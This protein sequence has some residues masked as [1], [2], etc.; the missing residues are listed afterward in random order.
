MFPEMLTSEGPVMASQSVAVVST[1][2]VAMVSTST[3]GVAGQSG[4]GPEERDDV[5]MEGEGDRW[6]H[7]T[8][9][10]SHTP[11]A[12]RHRSFHLL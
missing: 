2:A 1:S 7:V 11:E 8:I 4:P 3:A 5:F 6:G 10:P 9:T 12:A